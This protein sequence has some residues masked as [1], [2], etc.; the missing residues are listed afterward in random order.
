MFHNNI[1]SKTI[2][3]T[4]GKHKINKISINEY[5]NG[6]NSFYIGMY[7]LNIFKKCYPTIREHRM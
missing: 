5:V 3:V 1:S 6:I 7:Q 4:D 2:D